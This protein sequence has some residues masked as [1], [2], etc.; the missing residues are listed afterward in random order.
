MALVKCS[1]CGQMVSDKASKCPKCGN[2]IN[3]GGSKLLLKI[4][5][6][7]SAI[8]VIAL[9]VWLFNGRGSVADVASQDSLSIDISTENKSIST[10]N[11]ADTY[12]PISVILEIEKSGRGNVAKEKLQEYGYKKVVSKDNKDYWVKNAEVIQEEVGYGGGASGI[13]YVVKD[14]SKGSLAVVNCSKTDEISVFQIEIYE[15]EALERWKNQFLKLGYAIN[16][17][18]TSYNETEDEA[19]LQKE[20]WIMGGARLGGQWVDIMVFSKGNEEYTVKDNDGSAM[21][22]NPNQY[23][24]FKMENGYLLDTSYHY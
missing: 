15:K 3:H 23:T 24:I 9:G 8:A 21:V 11:S 7:I 16:Y 13:E 12:L 20:G 17:D 5:M 4:I 1:E 10:E 6:C 14:R 2:P 18:D 22:I 19:Q